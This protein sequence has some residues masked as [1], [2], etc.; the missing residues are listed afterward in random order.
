MNLKI[1]KPKK[2]PLDEINK[3]YLTEASYAIEIL[4]NDINDLCEGHLEKEDLAKVISCE[5]KCDRL[6][7][8]YV[9]ILFKNKRGLPFLIEDRYY[10]INKIDKKIVG[11]CEFVA[12]FLRVFPFEIYKDLIDEIKAINQKFFDSTSELIKCLDLIEMD[13]NLA[14]KKTFEIES[15]RRE[16]REIKFTIMEILFKKKGD[17]LRVYLTSKLVQYIYDIINNAEEIS[18]YLRGLIIKYPSK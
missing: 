7:E 4:Y 8:K 18:D 12:R 14:Y 3:Q 6:K 16:A 17:D 15:I 9:E 11:L 2:N 1:L 10:I 13:F 5:Q